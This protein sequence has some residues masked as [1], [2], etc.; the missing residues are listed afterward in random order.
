MRLAAL[1]SGGKDSTMATRL[2]ER[3]GHDVPILVTMRSENQ[4][5]YMFHTVN[6]DVTRL[7]AEAWGKKWVEAKTQGEKEVELDDLKAV[8]EGL[9]VDGVISGAIASSY[10]R[11]RVDRICRE[12]GLTHVSPLWGQDRAELLMQ[13]LIEDMKV[14]FTAVAAHG[15]DESWLGKEL[16]SETVSRL[17]RLRKECGVDPCGEGG[18]YES[19]V[20]DAPWFNQKITISRAEK[21]WDGLSGRY[22]VLDAHLVTKG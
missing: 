5:S 4:D 18:E 13:I 1:F 22:Q 15:L 19:L 16:D 7:Q 8:L 11:E 10:Q 6:I 14:I 12:L 21:T 9:D 17:L 20:L 2:A 3:M